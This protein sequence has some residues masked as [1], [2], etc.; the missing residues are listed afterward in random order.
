MRENPGVSASDPLRRLVPALIVLVILLAAAGPAAQ[1][2]PAGAGIRGAGTVSPAAVGIFNPGSMQGIVG[3]PLEERIKGSEMKTLTALKPLPPGLKLEGPFA[4]ETEWRIVGTPTTPGVSEVELQAENAANETSAPIS[5]TF[6]IGGINS[7][8]A[9]K[10]VVGTMVAV[11]VTGQELARLSSA[12]AL[13]EGL[14]LEDSGGET[15]WRI[16]G[17]PNGPLQ[18]E[19]ELQAKNMANETL[20][21]VRFP[22]TIAGIARLGPQRGTLGVAVNLSVKGV[23]LKTLEAERLPPGLKL[24]GPFESETEWRIVGTPT[25]VGVTNVELT[26]KNGAEQSPSPVGFEFTIAASEPPPGPLPPTGTGRL[27]VSPAGAFAAARSSC[28]GV[29]WSP[30][31]VATQWLLDG[32]PIA[33]ATAATFVAPRADDGHALSCRQTAKGP[34]GALALQTSAGQ[35]VHEQPAQ[36]AWPIG[37]AALRCT[38]PICM[39]DGISTQTPA[40]RSYPQQGAWFVAS[41]VR[42]VSAPWTSIAGTSTLPA[43]QSLAEAHAIRITLQRITPAATVT[44]ASQELNPLTGARDE[45]D[46]PPVAASPFAGNIAAAYGA[47]TMTAAELWGHVLPGAVGRPDRF[48]AGQGYIAYQLA[49]TGAVHR[50][51]QLVYNLVQADLGAKLRCAVTATDG[52][53]AAPTRATFLSPQYAVAAGSYCAPRRLGPLSGPQPLLALIGSRHCLAQAASGLGEIGGGRSDAAVRGG[54]LAVELECALTT[55]CAG[56]LSLAASARRTLAG[57]AVSLGAGAR[58]L[59][60]LRLTAA[61]RRLLARA[62]G[63]GLAGN[64]TLVSRTGARPLL[65]LRLRSL[66]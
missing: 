46:G 3:T 32:T 56:R 37:P 11:P 14:E 47:Q 57:A 59:I 24:E 42:C 53:A 55:R 4:S 10:G 60:T 19:V 62:G 31:S 52:P 64:L 9:Q 17:T 35:T 43:V 16:V 54:R 48:A 51:S 50:S 49:A 15:E 20:R 5:F 45:L 18:T 44:V 27:K 66:S 1:A 28:G 63:G 7:P 26:A 61:G 58:R 34:T 30:A 12:A 23:E 40:T 33:G 22:L 2:S 65:A 21:P 29:V 8:G 41:Q 39:E 25:S 38:T 36:P 6:T 13:P